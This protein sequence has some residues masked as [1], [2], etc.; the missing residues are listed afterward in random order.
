[1]SP[2][3]SN[4]L[5]EITVTQ[6]LYGQTPE[7]AA[8]QARKK[9]FA[10][11]LQVFMLNQDVIRQDTLTMTSSIQIAYETFKKNVKNNLGWQR[12]I[13]D[14]KDIHI[15]DAATNVLIAIDYRDEKVK[16][17]TRSSQSKLPL[18]LYPDIKPTEAS[19][20]Q[21]DAFFDDFYAAIAGSSI[22]MDIRFM[23]DGKLVNMYQ[24]NG[25][26][27]MINVTDRK[28]SMFN[29]LFNE[30]VDY[31]CDPFFDAVS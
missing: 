18:V 7:F 9:Q 3:L 23:P 30:A 11:E 2:L 5:R 14:K 6:M 15:T 12:D 20:G 25:K 21:E 24:N 26:M 29:P 27:F 4:Q 16:S 17:L 8:N 1:M 10:N 31:S 13:R 19:L 22:W 28:I